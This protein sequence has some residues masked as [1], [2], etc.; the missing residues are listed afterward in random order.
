MSNGLNYSALLILFA[1]SLTLHTS[2]KAGAITYL[3]IAEGIQGIKQIYENV[4]KVLNMT[5]G[6]EIKVELSSNDESRNQEIFKM[7]NVLSG[8]VDKIGS[9]V[10]SFH[11]LTN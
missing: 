8:N 4:N 9:Q 3:Q 11:D 10:S 7:I 2:N 5:M 1:I 6:T